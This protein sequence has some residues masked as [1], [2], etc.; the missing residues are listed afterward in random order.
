MESLKEVCQIITPKRIRD[1]ELFD[2]ETGNGK[3]SQLKKFYNG[4][5]SGLYK[6]D[7]DAAKDLY[8]AGPLDGRYSKLKT[9]LKKRLNNYLFLTDNN[10]ASYSGYNQA[11]LSCHK[12][13]ALCNILM[14][15]GAR[16]SAIKLARQLL[17]K[18]VKYTFNDIVM[19]CAKILKYY[20]SFMGELKEYQLYKDMIVKY[21]KIHDADMLAEDYY[22]QIIIHYAK[23]V[24]S[25]SN[26]A[27][28]AA[29]YLDEL[30]PLAEKYNSFTLNYYM[31][32]IWAF[33][34]QLKGDFESTLTVYD[35]LESYLNQN[36]VFYQNNLVASINAR[37]L[38]CYLHLNDFQQGAKAAHVCLKFYPKRHTNWFIFNEQYFL[39]AMRTANYLKAKTIF[40]EVAHQRKFK[41]LTPDRKEKW[42]IFEAY[43]N[44]LITTGELSPEQ[45]KN[46]RKKRFDIDIFINTLP[47][48][49]KDKRGYNIAILIIHILF[50]LK[51]G[52]FG[53]IIDRMDALRLYHSRHLKNEEDIR[54][55]LFIKMLLIMEKQSF[56][57][58]KTRHKAKKYFDHMRSIQF[59]H[60]GTPMDAEILPYETLWK[61]VL[62]ILQSQESR[63]KKLQIA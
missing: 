58:E 11:K 19:G 34:C 4:V 59:K 17:N 20:A 39:M 42:R 60:E 57:F 37:R 1:I 38:Q 22:Q 62:S 3:R 2:P 21:Q 30:K 47:I 8:D 12:N 43:L 13:L 32:N 28:L 16:N 26:M 46:Q 53:R 50:M 15:N 48:F 49:S 14:I 23:S 9:K 25:K 36:P 61:M 52:E 63:E 41:S 54:N 7:K 40:D 24:S 10:V 56:E 33:C 29:G 27:Q 5:A 45:I 35:L 51:K 55:K 6:T 31:Y 44:F 18:A